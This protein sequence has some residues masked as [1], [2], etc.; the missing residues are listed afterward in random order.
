[1]ILVWE[2]EKNNFLC[3]FSSILLQK[4]K[5]IFFVLRKKLRNWKKVPFFHFSI[6]LEDYE[7]SCNKL[8]ANSLAEIYWTSNSITNI[9][10]VNFVHRFVWAHS[11]DEEFQ[12]IFDGDSILFVITLFIMIFFVNLFLCLSYRKFCW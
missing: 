9:A 8:K 2:S 6:M 5:V 10:T 12:K 4:K 11:I 7:T 3:I 1:M